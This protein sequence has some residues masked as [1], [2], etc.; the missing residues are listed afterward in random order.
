MGVA[1]TVTPVV[2]EFYASYCL[3]FSIIND[4]NPAHSSAEQVAAEKCCILVIRLKNFL[5]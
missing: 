3:S 2:F 5:V 1:V 4:S